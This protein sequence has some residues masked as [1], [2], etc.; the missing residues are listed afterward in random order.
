MN[1]IP[2][3]FPVTGPPVESGVF[4][5]LATRACVLLHPRSRALSPGLRLGLLSPGCA[6]P[7]PYPSLGALLQPLPSF[8]HPSRSADSA[9]LSPQSLGC[10]FQIC[11]NISAQSNNGIL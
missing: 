10:V 7:A 9:Y 5:P 11:E 6:T 3:V 1:P 2:N 8:T 4:Y